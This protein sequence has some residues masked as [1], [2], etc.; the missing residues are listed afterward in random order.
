MADTKEEKEK[1]QIHIVSS[2]KGGCG[3]TAF[4]LFKAMEIASKARENDEEKNNLLNRMADVIWIDADFMGTA[5][6][7][8][9]YAK[10]EVAF[11]SAYQGHT[12]EILEKNDQELFKRGALASANKLCFDSKYVPYT[13]NDYLQENI[14]TL[15]SMV[16]HGYVLGNNNQDGNWSEGSNTINGLIDFIFASGAKESKNLYDYRNQLPAIAIGR[17]TYLM[18]MLL[19][20]ICAIGRTKTKAAGEKKDVQ[21]HYKHIVIDMPP[22]DDVYANA[23]LEIIYELVQESNIELH[24]YNLTTSDRGHIYAAQERLKDICAKRRS[25]GTKY[26]EKIHAVFSE[27]RKGEFITCE[28]ETVDRTMYDKCWGEINVCIGEIQEKFSIQEDTDIL[29]CP[30]QMEYYEFCRGMGKGEFRYEIKEKIDD[31]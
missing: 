11:R 17:F 19:S 16:I 21:F 9:F 28:G 7:V 13:I 26:H 15:S 5:S 30:F 31:K 18:R 10:D 12:I 24:L 8:L 2:V 25:R 4:S 20:R 1:V 27:I 22:G 3:K 6:K 29:F 23:L 14:H